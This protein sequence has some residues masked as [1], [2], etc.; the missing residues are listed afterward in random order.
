[1]GYN[2]NYNNN[3]SIDPRWD[4]Q[5]DEIDIQRQFSNNVTKQTGL[6]LESTSFRPFRPSL[7]NVKELERRLSNVEKTQKIN[8]DDININGV[9]DDNA[10]DDDDEVL[11]I[12]K[13]IRN[14]NRNKRTTK[15]RNKRKTMKMKK[16]K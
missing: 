5:L 13:V 8:Y 11:V 3:K 7:L 12:K 4:D 16:R 2:N 14:T 6:E 15:H 1:M 10:D 9:E